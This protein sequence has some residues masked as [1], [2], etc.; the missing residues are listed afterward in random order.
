[1]GATPEIVVPCASAPW[2]PAAMPATCVAWN[3]PVGSNG[4]LAY[5]DVGAAGVNV[6]WNPMTQTIPY[7][8]AAEWA[9]LLGFEATTTLGEMLDE[10]IPWIDQAIADGSI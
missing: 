5:F 10:V 7:V 4:T 2:L 6:R 3:D 8:P 1:M 9:K